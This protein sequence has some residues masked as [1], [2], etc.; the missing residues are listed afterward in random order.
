M[1]GHPFSNFRSVLIVSVVLLTRAEAVTLLMDYRYDT[2]A[3]GFFT[4]N[5]QAKAALDA[6]AAD[7]SGALTSSLGAISAANQRVT[8]TNG[9]TSVTFDWSFGI[10]NPSTGANVVIKDTSIAADTVVIFAGMRELAGNTLGQGGMGGSSISISGSGIESEWAGAVASAE[11]QAN[12]VFGRG[13]GPVS[14]RFDDTLSFGGTSA[15]YSISTG[16]AV[17]NLWFDIDTNDDGFADSLDQLDSYW[18]FNH[19]TEVAA[20]KIDF[21]SVALH[22]ILHALGIGN[23]DSWNELVIG[24]DW[25]GTSANTVVGDGL[26]L[27]D[28]DGSHISSEIMSIRISDGEAQSPVMIDSIAAGQR[29]QLTTLDLATLEDIGWQTAVIPEPGNHLLAMISLSLVLFQRRRRSGR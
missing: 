13:G 5:P 28:S 23:S 1:K 16:L 6:A 24:N 29:R 2:D 4:A 25:Y 20:G 14:Y 10:T 18:H 12:Q 19:M 9:S 15:S 3:H 17:A 27:I 26:N 7:I 22:E 8:G 21:Y 11:Q